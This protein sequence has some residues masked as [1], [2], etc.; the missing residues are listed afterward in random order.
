MNFFGIQT[1]SAKAKPAAREK[2]A[3]D[4]K[5]NA[6]PTAQSDAAG[7]E[8]PPPASQSDA[9]PCESNAISSPA[10][11]A[12]ESQSETRPPVLFR[13]S[14]RET[15]TSEKG[16]KV[17]APATG[18]PASNANE[19]AAASKTKSILPPAKPDLK[20]T[21]TEGQ[22]VSTL[23]D[24]AAGSVTEQ[25]AEPPEEQQADASRI[26]SAMTSVDESL[27]VGIRT[28]LWEDE[29]PFRPRY[30]A[31]PELWG[32]VMSAT[33]GAEL[34]AYSDESARHMSDASQDLQML[35]LSAQQSLEIFSQKFKPEMQGIAGSELR[36][37]LNNSVA[38]LGRAHEVSTA[39]L[40]Q[41]LRNAVIAERMNEFVDH[42]RKV[43]T[44]N[45]D[46]E[47]SFEGPT[48]VNPEGA[49]K[50]NAKDSEKAKVDVKKK[51]DE[52][53][54][55]VL[56]NEL[57]EP[58]A[59]CDTLSLSVRTIGNVSSEEEVARL[60]SKLKAAKALAAA[61]TAEAS[62]AQNQSRLAAAKIAKVRKVAGQQKNIEMIEGAIWIMETEAMLKQLVFITWGNGAKS[63]KAAAA[64]A[65][66]EAAH[67]H[68]QNEELALKVAMAR[69]AANFEGDKISRI[70]EAMWIIE[71]N[72]MLK[73][74]IFITW[75]HRIQFDSRN[76]E[77]KQLAGTGADSKLSDPPTEIECGAAAGVVEDAAA[78]LDAEDA[79]AVGTTQNQ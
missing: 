55:P 29:D 78:K 10:A 66:A 14:K 46:A 56:G 70:E 52:A 79:E 35:V 40:N 6:P 68:I 61:A 11:T 34:L 18:K 72:A 51:D 44:R 17:K 21:S 30:G 49:S 75:A 71:T 23:S 24:K 73:Q 9:G 53:I 58:F 22:S 37:F 31:G 62:E 12:T 15:G 7:K 27:P 26:D 69:R 65:T 5:D 57:Q 74:F 77:Q 47:N 3:S 39:I 43:T 4:G 1:K 33:T 2:P 25:V 28:A 45:Q 48:R 38:S 50:E 64:V 13:P 60:K 42:D 36:S 54:N 32:D 8:S 63:A 67:A 16:A 76:F 19:D 41:S 20:S 59:D